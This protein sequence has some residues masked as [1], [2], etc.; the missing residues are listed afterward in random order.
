[1]NWDREGLQHTLCQMPP[2][3]H[4]ER[5]AAEELLLMTTACFV[6]R[7]QAH[8]A[9][10]FCCMDAVRRSGKGTFWV[11]PEMCLVA[12]KQRRSSYKTPT[13]WRTPKS[14]FFSHRTEERKKKS[15][16]SVQFPASAPKHRS[17]G[18]TQRLSLQCFSS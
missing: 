2:R 16:L 15:L 18:I 1:M 3:Q 5:Q 8:M 10:I 7:L 12:L 11:L 6:V 4:L 9:G 14:M 17:A 13:L